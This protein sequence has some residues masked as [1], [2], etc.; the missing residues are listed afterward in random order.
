MNLLTAGIPLHGTLVASSAAFAPIPKLIG[1][2]T[3]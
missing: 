2:D 3:W 1:N